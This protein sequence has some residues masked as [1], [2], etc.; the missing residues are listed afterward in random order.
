[1]F[2]LLKL[3]W[4]KQKDYILFK[5]LII[6]YIVF[7]PAILMIGKKIPPMPAGE[8]FDPQIMLFH[9]PTVWEFLAYIG[10]WLAFFIFGFLA[11]IIITNEYSYKTMRQNILTGMQRKHW[12]WS[13][14][15]FLVT[16]G[17][18]ASL[19]Y[20]LCAITIGVIHGMDDTLYLT[21]I[22]KNS[23]YTIRYFIMCLGYM[24]FGML[25]GLLIRRTGIA[26][27]AFI[28]YSFFLENVLRG[29]H[30]YYIRNETMHYFP[31]NVMEDLC[32][33]PFAEI[34][35]EFT[36]ENG[37]ALFVN[38]NLAMV[39]ATGYILLFGWLGYRRLVKSDL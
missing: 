25:V 16:I 38:P 23:E 24:S 19:Y 21:T 2:H 20:A 10:N 18:L 8:V 35:E 31:L 29:I 4:L 7:L 32:P 17:L 9:F 36:R 26:L 6:A 3:E 33:M 39:L 11:V 15:V 37:F 13:K 14:V 5:I 27:F 1:M 28:G 30:L 34:A 22:F 12:F